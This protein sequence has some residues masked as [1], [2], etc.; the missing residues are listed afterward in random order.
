M[1]DTVVVAFGR[2]NPP[3]LGH[4]KLVHKMED[5]A[6]EN[7]C[8]ARLYLSHSVDKKNE[9]KNPLPYESK[10]EWVDKAFGD[11]VDVIDSDAK[12]IIF[13]LHD[14]MEEGFKHIIYVGGEDRIGGDEDISGTISKYNGYPAKENMY[15]EFDS[16]EFKNAGSRNESSDDLLERASASLARKFVIE[17]D[18]DSFCEIEPFDETDCIILFEELKEFMGV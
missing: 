5:L 10:I 13:V 12:T 6:K 2:M 18:F 7:N 14:L 3:T 8:E 15:Y 1:K 9:R 11:M 4:L 17:D 16:I